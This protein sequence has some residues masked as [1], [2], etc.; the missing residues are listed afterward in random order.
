M[1]RKQGVPKSKGLPVIGSAD[2]AKSEEFV[3]QIMQY[4]DP[5]MNN[6]L[7]SIDGIE[8]RLAVVE[9]V[10][11]VF[12]AKVE[13]AVKHGPRERSPLEEDNINRGRSNPAYIES[14]PDSLGKGKEKK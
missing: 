1:D 7:Q 13:V 5:I 4:L 12:P 2:K 6:I 9:E 11:Q 10:K 14:L 3:R 8:R